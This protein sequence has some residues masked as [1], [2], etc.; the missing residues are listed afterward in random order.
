MIAIGLS[1]IAHVLLMCQ[2]VQLP[3]ADSAS[4]SKAFMLQMLQD[5]RRTVASHLD[6]AVGV[7]VARECPVFG[8]QVKVT[9][10][11]DT[12]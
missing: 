12:I 6:L 2:T 10:P 7:H 3:R 1:D 8:C 11:E 5:T 9:E 4:I